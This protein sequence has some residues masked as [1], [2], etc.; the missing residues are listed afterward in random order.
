MGTGVRG[1]LRPASTHEHAQHLAE[2]WKLD[3]SSRESRRISYVQATDRDGCDSGHTLGFGPLQLWCQIRIY[4]TARDGQ[5]WSRVVKIP[6][7]IKHFQRK[8]R[9]KTETNF[10]VMKKLLQR[11]SSLRMHISSCS[12]DCGD[13]CKFCLSLWLKAI[14]KSLFVSPRALSPALQSSFHPA[15]F[16]FLL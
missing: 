5:C 2:K 13:I 10:R 6:A 14:S 15:A 8:G 7:Q 11:P 9:V 1:P 12:G 16:C 3:L 4:F